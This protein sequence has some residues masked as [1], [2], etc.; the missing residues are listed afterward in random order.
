MDRCPDGLCP[1]WCIT[2]QFRCYTS[3]MPTTRPRHL[4]GCGHLPLAGPKP[5]TVAG[6]PCSGRSPRRPTGAGRAA[7]PQACSRSAT[8][9]HPHRRLRT[10]LPGSAPRG[11]AE[12]I[13][14]DAS[15][16]IAYLDADDSQHAA[17]ETPVS[18]THLRAHETDS[19]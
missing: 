19:Y 15:V 6:A 5:S 1:G 11:V 16:L 4:A 2:S 3:W 8:Q 7:A 18:Y 12:M 14:L 13:V 17:A 10:R 9:R